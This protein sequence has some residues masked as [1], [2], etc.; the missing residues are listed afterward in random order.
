MHDLKVGMIF[1]TKEDYAKFGISRGDTEGIVNYMLQLKD[2]N[3][4]ALITDQ[5]GIIK[6]SF[7]SK[8]DISVQTLAR[9]YFNGGG[10]KNASGG[11]QHT[12]LREA[13]DKFKMVIP[14]FVQSIQSLQSLI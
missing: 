8:G 4:A 2:V 14:K 3:I 11:Y 7:R 1:L 10:H 9:E 6:F 13:I 5:N 12:S